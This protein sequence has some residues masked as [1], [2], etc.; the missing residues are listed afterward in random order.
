MLTVTNLE[1][2]N[3]LT[4]GMKIFAE[5]EFSIVSTPPKIS[6]KSK[7]FATLLDYNIDLTSDLGLFCR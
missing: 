7:N 3:L 1:V 4:G 5:L 6:N 2:L